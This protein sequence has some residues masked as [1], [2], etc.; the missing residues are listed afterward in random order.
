MMVDAM[1]RYDQDMDTTVDEVVAD[2]PIFTPD[3]V[4]EPAVRLRRR[5]R[6]RGPVEGPVGGV[7]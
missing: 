5:A 6:L 3:N 2:A 4:E 1:A 7:T